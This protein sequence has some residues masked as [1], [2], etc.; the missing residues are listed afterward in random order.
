MGGKARAK[1]HKNKLSEWGKRGG[2]PKK[3]EFYYA[4]SRDREREFVRIRDNQTCQRCGKIWQEGQ[5][6]FDVHHLDEDMFGKNR[7]KMAHKYD[8]ENNDKL[9]TFCHKCHFAWHTE[10]GHIKGRIKLTISNKNV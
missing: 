1:K 9:I 2:R 5:R 8:K 7:M 3:T 10:R 4:S 6:K